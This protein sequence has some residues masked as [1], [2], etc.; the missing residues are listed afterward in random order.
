MQQW[1]DFR[2]DR[3]RNPV[4]ESIVDRVEEVATC[5]IVGPQ[6]HLLNKMVGRASD[7]VVLLRSTADATALRDVARQADASVEIVVGG[8]DRP[9]RTEVRR[10]SS[11]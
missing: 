9:D 10:R 5:L 8:L 6:T 4:V 3:T 1:S 11:S 7:V 2:P